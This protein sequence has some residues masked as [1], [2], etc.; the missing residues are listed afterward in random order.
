M[1]IP[2]PPMNIP[3]PPKINILQEKKM[4][5][6]SPINNHNRNNMPDMDLKNDDSI[7]FDDFDHNS[8]LTSNND[9]KGPIF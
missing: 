4:D 7:I 5:P 1:N 2:P 6:V 8:F 3:P 9:N